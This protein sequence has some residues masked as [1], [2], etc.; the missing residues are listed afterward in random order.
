[1]LEDPPDSSSKLSTV[2]LVPSPPSEIIT[3]T[4]GPSLLEHCFQSRVTPVSDRPGF[5]RVVSFTMATISRRQLP[6]VFYECC[7]PGPSKSVRADGR[8]HR[9]YAMYPNSTESPTVD[10]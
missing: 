4:P 2:F 1:M 3:G 6:P 5:L 10:R 7:I 8:H 9:L